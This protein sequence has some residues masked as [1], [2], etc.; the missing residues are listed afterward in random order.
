MNDVIQDVLPNL[1]QLHRLLGGRSLTLVGMMGSGKSTIGRRVAR[2]LGLGFHDADR[3]IEDAAGC[4]I[5]EIFATHG[6]AFFRDREHAV[7]NRLLQETSMVLA[8]GGGAFM[9]DRTREVMLQRSVCI[10][11]RA[12]LDIL[13]ERVS[14]KDNRPLL[15]NKDPRQ[16]LTDLARTRHPI[17]AQAHLVV[18]SGQGSHEETVDGLLMALEAYLHSE[19]LRL[20]QQSKRSL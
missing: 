1:A 9:N 7:I 10:W 17:Y 11:L 4:S 5:P 16:V 20:E 8:T 15:Q 14:R 18:E 2:R 6:E 12:D 19:Q 13:V 3:E